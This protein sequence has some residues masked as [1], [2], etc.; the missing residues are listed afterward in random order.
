MIHRI[1]GDRSARHCR[2]SQ[3]GPARYRDPFFGVKISTFQ[4]THAFLHKTKLIRIKLLFVVIFYDFNVIYNIGCI[5]DFNQIP[6][7]RAGETN[8]Y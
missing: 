1:R 2:E 6:A 4:V 5:I 3:N 8:L 7:S